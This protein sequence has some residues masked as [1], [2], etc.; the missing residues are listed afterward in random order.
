[1]SVLGAIPLNAN[2]CC[3]SLHWGEHG[4]RGNDPGSCYCHT[5]LSLRRILPE[6]QTVQNY[7]CFTCPRSP[8]TFSRTPIRLSI[9]S[10]S[11]LRCS[12]LR[13]NDRNEASVASIGISPVLSG[14]GQDSRHA[15]PRTL[16]QLFL[17]RFS[18]QHVR[19]LIG[20][21]ERQNVGHSHSLS[22]RLTPLDLAPV[23]HRAG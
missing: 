10:I 14:D 3:A 23:H 17:G 16:R 20:L 11:N 22:L 2:A 19:Q 5:D 1:M 12:S 21:I 13:S 4:T 15:Q 7:Q 18:Y 6:K 9:P 8:D